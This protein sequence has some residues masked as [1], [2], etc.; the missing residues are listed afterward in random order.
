MKSDNGETGNKPLL[1]C[2]RRPDALLIP[3]YLSRA[4]FGCAATTAGND[5]RESVM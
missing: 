3:G 5:T 1:A 2:A 4:A